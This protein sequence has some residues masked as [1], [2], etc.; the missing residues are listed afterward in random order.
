MK[1]THALLAIAS[2]SCLF[3][4]SA[5]TSD[6][7]SSEPVTEPTFTETAVHLNADGTATVTARTITMSDQKRQLALRDAPLEATSVITPVESGVASSSAALSKDGGCAGS[8]FWLFDQNKRTGNKICF[9]GSGA[10]HLA[11]FKDCS[12]GQD[13]ATCPTWAQGVGHH[14]YWAGSATGHFQDRFS[15]CVAPS[16]YHCPDFKAFQASEF[17]SFCEAIKPDLN[18]ADNTCIPPNASVDW[19]S[20]MTSS[21]SNFTPGGAVTVQ[22]LSSTSSVLFTL[23]ATADSSGYVSKLIGD[24]FKGGIECQGNNCG[25]CGETIKMIDVV[26]GVSATVASHVC[27]EANKS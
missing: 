27:Y 6:V 16:Q 3:G 20:P 9:F 11:D 12:P 8:S 17:L 26:S 15:N 2:I 10:V 13:P 19:S 23:S 1:T 22:V 21:G 7:A 14:S 5:S 4:C 25:S 24:G 18:L